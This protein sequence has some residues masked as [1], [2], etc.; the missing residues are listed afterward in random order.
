[1][2]VVNDVGGPVNVPGGPPDRLPGGRAQMPAPAAG[3]A[4][5]RTGF[6][7]THASAAVLSP[8]PGPPCRAASRPTVARTVTGMV[9]TA[10][11]VSGRM[12]ATWDSS[13]FSTEQIQAAAPKRQP[14]DPSCR[15]AVQGARP[16]VTSPAVSLPGH[17]EPALT[18]RG[19]RVPR[20]HLPCAATLGRCRSPCGRDRRPD[21]TRWALQAPRTG[22]PIRNDAGG[23]RSRPR[24]LG[25]GVRT[26]ASQRRGARG[27]DRAWRPRRVLAAL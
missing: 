5:V 2:N 18:E 6:G 14:A 13:F 15:R 24:G 19:T 11:R 3:G 23:I 4:A 21:A 8:C 26:S 7:R 22:G 25:E 1:V 17:A 16:H 20:R 12:R 10:N 9:T 27:A